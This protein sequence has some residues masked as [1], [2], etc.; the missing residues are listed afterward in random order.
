MADRPTGPVQPPVI[1]L[2]ARAGTSRAETERPSVADAAS[3]SSQS[4]AR[5]RA[6]GRRLNLSDVNWPL[7]VGAI[8]GGAVLGTI[9]T[10]LLAFAIPLPSHVTPAPDVTPQLVAESERID[11]L[12]TEFVALKTTAE[13]TQA[14]LDTTSGDLRKTIDAVSKSVADVKA[15]I[16]PAQAP[17]DLA[18]LETEIR[19]LKAQVDAIGAGAS[20]ADAGAIAKSLS[21][22]ETSITSLTTRLNGVDSTVTALRTDL[23]AARKALTDHI[24][25]ALPNEAGPAMKLPLILSGLESAFATGKPF[26]AELASL[27]SVLPDLAVTPALDA[28]APAGLSRP[29]A[30]MQTFETA[31]PE[32]LGA[33]GPGSG[34]WVQNSLDWAKSLLA[35]RPAGEIEGNSPEAIVSRLEGAMGR[36][37]Y[38][39]AATLIASLPAPMQAAAAPVATEIATHADADALVADLRARALAPVETT[40]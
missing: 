9:L 33:R 36:R 20:G 21:D 11:A 7:L 34:D 27:K 15:S 5:A 18:P 12:E 29:D 37:D 31:L 30:L 22:V 6:T 28:A 40:P 26:K 8:A 4:S 10:Y 13:S 3:A 32:I 25:T 1:D 39:A 16:P 14:S 24:S 19:T 35:L 38:A 23:D 17:V 2:T